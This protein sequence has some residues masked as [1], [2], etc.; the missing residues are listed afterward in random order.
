M[1]FEKLISNKIREFSYKKIF[2]I[3]P[4]SLFKQEHDSHKNYSTKN[5]ENHIKHSS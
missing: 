1:E 2:S 3:K 5:Q 4:K